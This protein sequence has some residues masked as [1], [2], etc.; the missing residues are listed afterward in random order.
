LSRL[1]LE[2]TVEYAAGDRR[3]IEIPHA[4]RQ[5][6]PVAW[7]GPAI[8]RTSF[9]HAGRG[10][11]LFHG[12]SYAC[13]VKVNGKEIGTHEGL[14]DAFALEFDGIGLNE[15]TVEVFKNG[16]ARYPVREVASGFLPFVYWPFGGIYQPVELLSSEPDLEP[17]APPTR[18]IVS[19]QRIFVDDQPFYPRGVLTWGWYPEYGHT[20]P[21]EEVIKGE[22]A[23]VQSLGFNLIKFCLWAPPHRYLELMREAGMEAWLELPLWDPSA[24]PERQRQMEHEIGRIVR[25]YRRHDN[26]VVW[27]VGCELSD[28]TPP[29]FRQRLYEMVR[30]ETACPLVKDNSGGAEMYGGDLREF[31]DFYD[32]H[33]YCDTMF[34]P[35][36]LDTLLPG[37]RKK[38]PILLGEFNDI[39]VHRDLPRL[40]RE[41]PYWVSTDHDLNAQ[42]VRWQHDMP[43]VLQSSR[44][45]EE[46]HATLEESSR[47]KALFIRKFVQEAVRERGEIGGY[48]I[49]GWRDT[50][51]SSA[52]FR[53]DWGALRFAPDEVSAWNGREVLFTIPN[54]RPPWIDGGN[55]PG[56]TD[57]FNH[58]EGQVYWRIGLHSERPAMG[59]L[60]WRVVGESCIV[61]EGE[62]EEMLC[63]AL[64]ATEVGQIH[65]IPEAPGEFRLEVTFAEAANSWPVWV[66][67]RRDFNSLEWNV[68]D[69]RGVLG[70]WKA[71]GDNLLSIGWSDEVRQAL[72][73][74]H[75]AVV[76]M[77]EGLAMPFWRECAFEFHDQSFWSRLPFAEQWP[78]LMPICSDRVLDPAW[79]NRTLGAYEV[80]MNRVDTRTYAEHP[81]LV[82]ADKCFITT[83]RP[84]GGL[85]IQPTSFARN[86]AGQEFLWR[87]L[88]LSEG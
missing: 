73:A 55:R 24:D 8:Y 49:T 22:I 34:Y 87:L 3:K 2:W 33:P 17:P 83:L 81:V 72:G 45:A 6:V 43:G 63:G 19:G 77:Q 40:K 36:V 18:V 54:R 41:M 51:I 23:A 25:Q 10:W 28:S 84:Y 79:L 21:S 42:G 48:V 1:L 60:A 38:Q 5:D 20:N 31:G 15:L 74:G 13:S 80:L 56:F 65:W 50:P 12:V 4:W 88:T 47:R 39:D 59:K 71:T 85:G 29:E 75:R 35:L 44:F 11:L 62:G 57:S 9:H 30:Q 64:E 46:P 52:G 16:G 70:P 53:D 78:R 68:R 32:F 86:P 27:T 58:F 7:E 76:L 26:I 37:A 82:R 61:A 67:P 69:M 14:W 66:V